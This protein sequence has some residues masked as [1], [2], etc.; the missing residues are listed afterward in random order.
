LTVTPVLI[1]V[2]PA[3]AGIQDVFWILASARMTVPAEVYPVLD[4]GPE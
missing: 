3:K 1:L 2:I 4:T